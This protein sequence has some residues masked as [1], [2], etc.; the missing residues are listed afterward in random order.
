[1]N[2]VNQSTED[3]LAELAR[4]AGV[5]DDNTDANLPI[6]NLSPNRYVQNLDETEHAL[7]NA[8]APVYQR[9]RNLVTIGC[10]K[11]IDSDEKEHLYRAIVQLNAV[12]LREIVARYCAFKKYDGRS[13]KLVSTLPPE[14]LMK[15][16]VSRASFKFPVLKAVVNHPCITKSGEIITAPGYHAKTGIYYDPLGVSYPEMPTITVENALALATAA[17]DRIKKLFHTFK[18]VDS[19]SRSVAISQLLTGVSRQALSAAPVHIG[20]AAVRGSG[21]SK[22]TRICA[23]VT[24]GKPAPAINQGY[25]HEEFEKRLASMLMAGHVMIHL[26]NCS[27]IVD[28][29]LL[30]SVSTEETVALRILGHS[31]MLEI[32]TGALICP[33]GNN[34]SVRGDAIRRCVKYRL[35]PEVERPELLQF[36]YDPVEDTTDNRAAIVIAALTILKARHVAKPKAPEIWQSFEGWSNTV[37]SALLW[38]GM[39]D[40]CDTTEDLQADDPE[41]AEIRA[42]YQQWWAHLEDKLVTVNEVI[43]RA[44]H[45][46]LVL[47]SDG[48]PVRDGDDK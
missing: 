38:L 9:D 1:M 41:L 5:S 46:E 22:I 48:T 6:V 10:V 35:D 25:T 28:G 39:A 40:P 12:A 16:L 44:V 19:A 18:F 24:I 7:I 14:Y 8:N 26:D 29:D 4:M 42:V 43:K 2:D 11:A 37:R 31:K 32:T 45:K 34:I 30:N 15:G 3:E 33:N 21:K 23:I 20:D 36:E 13:D 17:L 27:A 47:G